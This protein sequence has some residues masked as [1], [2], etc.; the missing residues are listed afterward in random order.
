ML[1]AVL[2]L[3]RD[4]HDIESEQFAGDP[5]ERY[6]EVYL[7]ALAFFNPSWSAS[8]V[9]DRSEGCHT[10][11]L[12][13]DQ[14]RMYLYPPVIGP[15]PPG[16]EEHHDERDNGNNATGCGPNA[17]IFDRLRKGVQPRKPRLWRHP[18]SRAPCRKRLGRDSFSEVPR[19]GGSGLAEC[20]ALEITQEQSGKKLNQK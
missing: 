13:H 9:A 4:I 10:S 19:R 15:L 1:N 5:G 16:E 14:L 17:R 3:A 7:H 8:R 12:V 11:S 18:V 2:L 6:V 20:N